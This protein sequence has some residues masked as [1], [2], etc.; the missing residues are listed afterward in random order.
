VA[1]SAELRENGVYGALGLPKSAGK[2][3]PF[4]VSARPVHNEV[5]QNL[6]ADRV[7]WMLDRFL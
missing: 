4:A 3:G 7:R 2:W 1:K 6:M 5:F